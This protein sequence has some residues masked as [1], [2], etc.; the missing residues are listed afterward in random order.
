MQILPERKYLLA[1]VRR[2]LAAAPRRC[3]WFAVGA[4]MLLLASVLGGG[5]LALDAGPVGAS[6]G[7]IVIGFV[8]TC[9]GPTA[10][11]NVVAPP[12]KPGW[13][14]RMPPVGSTVARS[15]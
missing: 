6:S 2:L 9:S 8:C 3:S 4:T 11:A 12:T 7:P 1:V 14:R 10:S 15:S 13:T 5:I